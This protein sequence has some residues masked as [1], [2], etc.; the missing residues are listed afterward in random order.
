MYLSQYLRGVGLGLFYLLFTE[1]E[2]LVGELLPLLLELVPRL[3]RR[4]DLRG[5]SDAAGNAEAHGRITV[6]P[7]AQPLK[8]VGGR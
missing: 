6:E 7:F 4:F 5:E 2:E 8:V 3:F 1:R